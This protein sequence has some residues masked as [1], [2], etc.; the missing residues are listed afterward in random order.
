AVSGTDDGGVN[1]NRSMTEAEWARSENPDEMLAFLRG[2]VSDRKLR[3]FHVSCC[4]R[5]WHLLTDT[6]CREAI[7]AAEQFVDGY[8]DSN[9]L[10]RHRSRAQEAFLVAKEAEYLA[11]S[12]SNFN[13]TRDY[14]DVC[15]GLFVAAATRAAVMADVCGEVSLL[16]AY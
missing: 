11:E 2:K 12:K 4:R 3:L 5:I 13:I 1:G 6:R 16:D 15:A 8:I 10:A 9:R 14:Q 7:E